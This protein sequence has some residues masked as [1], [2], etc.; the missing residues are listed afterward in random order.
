MTVNAFAPRVGRIPGGNQPPTPPGM[1]QPLTAMPSPPQFLGPPAQA[2]GG[3]MHATG[4]MPPGQPQMGDFRTAMQGWHDARP[5]FS[6]DPSLN[7]SRHDQRMDWRQS[8]MM[9]WRDQ[10]PMPWNFG[11]GHPGMPGGPNTLFPLNPG[12]GLAPGQMPIMTPGGGT[13]GAPL[14]APM[15]MQPVP[16]GGVGSSL[17]VIGATPSTDPYGMPTY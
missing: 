8:T 10:R 15:I 9:P 13:T 5:Q 17:G 12:T 2:P 3:D 6:Y 7:T 4:Q 16:A 11:M 14:Q 1:A